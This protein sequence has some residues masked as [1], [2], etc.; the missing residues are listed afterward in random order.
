MHLQHVVGMDLAFDASIEHERPQEI[1]A[2]PRVGTSQTHHSVA[3]VLHPLRASVPSTLTIGQQVR[4][5]LRLQISVGP[6]EC[7]AQTF[8]LGLL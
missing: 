7:G 1:P 6:K 8:L 4:E 2:P 3:R 5:Q